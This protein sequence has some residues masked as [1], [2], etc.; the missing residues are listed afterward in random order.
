LTSTIG[1]GF[2][3]ITPDFK[4]A[5]DAR[6][7]KVRKATKLD[8]SKHLRGYMYNSNTFVSDA[9]LGAVISYHNA[10]LHGSPGY[11]SNSLISGLKF[12]IEMLSQKKYDLI[13][14]YVLI[15]VAK[16][17]FKSAAKKLS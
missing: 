17:D 5:L 10:L 13:I 12:S 2:G 1:S 15:E 3:E 9:I 14:R 4:K 6:I 8:K 7:S 16:V 11:D